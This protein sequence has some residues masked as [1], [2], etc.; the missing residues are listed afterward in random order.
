MQTLRIFSAVALAAGS[1]LG[2]AG[3]PS[4]VR[5][6]Q[7]A[8]SAGDRTPQ[9]SE[10]YLINLPIN[11]AHLRNLLIWDDAGGEWRVMRPDEAPGQREGLIVLHLWADYCAPC[12]EEFPLLRDLAAA[13][14]A[15]HAGRVRFVYLSETDS[16]SAMESF[17]KKYRA[18][19]P[20]APLYQDTAAA[21]ASSLRR[22]LAGSLS[23]PLTVVLDGRGVVRYAIV[24]SIARR[25]ADLANAVERLVGAELTPSR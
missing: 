5:S 16:S 24:G 22:E 19:M 1:L 17:L 21:I 7:A 2:A 13:I 15:Q 18:R 23:L 4:A 12:R 3:L 25:Q 20:K 11:P 6:A 10:R 8:R 14:E 9:D